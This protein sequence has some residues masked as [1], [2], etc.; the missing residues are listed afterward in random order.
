MRATITLACAVL[1]PVLVGLSFLDPP[2]GDPFRTYAL[3]LGLAVLFLGLVPAAFQ[4]LRRRRRRGRSAPPA[5]A[6]ELANTRAAVAEPGPPAVP[7]KADVALRA[8]GNGAVEPWVRWYHVVAATT[9]DVPARHARVRVAVT[10]ERDNGTRWQWERGE[11]LELTRTG[12]RIPIVIGAVAE[13]AHPTGAGWSVPFRNWYLTPSSSGTLGRFLAPFIK[14]V[15]H[16]FEVTVTWTEGGG[17]EQ[18]SSETFELRFWGEP[19]SE[20]RFM[21]AG[22][23]PTYQDQVGGLR[24]LRE[25]GAV[26]RKQGMLLPAA[27]LNEWLGRVESWATETRALIGEVSRADSEYFWNANAANAPLFEGVRIHDDRHRQALRTLHERLSRL[28]MF[29]RG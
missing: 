17:V 4:S 5:I 11:R 26:L 27:G 16:C 9:S 24:E 6:D 19:S 23:R 7:A 1:G 14:G 15:R 3:D 21:R 29:V 8:A 10:G 22:E 28:Q 2:V 13:S 12:A 25:R 20:P 18:A